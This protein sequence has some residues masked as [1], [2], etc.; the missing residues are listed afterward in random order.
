MK[1]TWLVL[2]LSIL[3]VSLQA[4][5][6]NCPRFKKCEC[7]GDYKPPR[8]VVKWFTARVRTDWEVRQHCLPCGRRIPYKV[9]V[10]TYRD[11]FSD[12]SQRTW[13]CVVADSEVTLGK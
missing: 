3:T 2:L 9:K 11:R 5:P 13:K 4:V 12:G 6:S 10:I 8:G 1:I 7:V